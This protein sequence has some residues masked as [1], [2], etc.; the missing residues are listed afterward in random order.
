[1][2]AV[3]A[4]SAVGAVLIARRRGGPVLML[5]TAAGIVLMTASLPTEVLRSIWSPAAPVFPFTLLIFVAWTVACGDYR[6]LP[7]AV[8]LASFVTHCHLAYLVP[9]AALLSVALVGLWWTSRRGDPSS[10]PRDRRRWITAAAVVAL[11]CWSAPVVDQVIHTAGGRHVYGNLSTLVEAIGDRNEPVG[12][13]GGAYAVVRAVGVPAWWLQQDQSP[14]VRVFEIFARPGVGSIVTATALVLALV[15]LAAA[16][17]RR[18]RL[19][20]VAATLVALA[21][22]ASLMLVTASFPNVGS[23]VFPYSYASWLASPLG[24]WTWI[25]AGW[26]IATLWPPRLGLAAASGVGV[27]V[28]V[29]A[30]VAIALVVVATQDRDTQHRLYD[31]VDGVTDAVQ[32][33]IPA[34]AT[35]YVAGSS[36]PVEGAIVHTLRQRGDVVGSNI[37]NQ[38]GMFYVDRS[39][40]YDYAISVTPGTSVPDGARRIADF[41]PD[42]NVDHW[43]TVT[44]GRSPPSG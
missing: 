19:D 14:V 37:G 25:A 3:N 18:K 1:M 24:L 10:R 12:L 39:R 22:V 5:V 16:G 36:L 28:L 8:G 41:R 26:S 34:G 4:L 30:V 17:F 21:L 38:L 9:S 33:A 23:S 32:R 42:A 15:A 29:A 44:L 20:V 27:P 13:K 40:R 7:L 11:I 43:Y 6:L 31:P 35:V 2:G